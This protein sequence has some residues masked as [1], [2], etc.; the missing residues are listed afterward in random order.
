MVIFVTGG[1]GFIGSS[2][3]RNLIKNT[4]HKVVNIDSLTYAGNLVSLKECESSKK[5]FFEQIDI[6][7]KNISG[8]FKTFRPDILIHLA[9][10]SH[11]DRSI[12]SPKKFI[13][14]NIEG[15]FNLLENTRTYLESKN[16]N[17]KSS[18]RFHHI[19]TDEVFGDLEHEASFLVRIQPMS[20]LHHIRHQRQHLI[21]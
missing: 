14:T 19:S 21:T 3:V 10:E 15:T 11:V 6:R 17:K 12:E 13:E 18:F 7:S 4:D 16:N 2:V 8:L 1:A 20:H 9:A 5:Y